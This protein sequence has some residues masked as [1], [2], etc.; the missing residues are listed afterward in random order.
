LKFN[1]VKPE[2]IPADAVPAPPGPPAPPTPQPKMDWRSLDSDLNAA[3]SIDIFNSL[4]FDSADDDVDPEVE[5]EPNDPRTLPSGVIAGVGFS[6]RG[7][8]GDQ[9]HG[10]DRGDRSQRGAGDLVA[11][12]AGLHVQL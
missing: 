2:F 5:D 4:V 7:Q 1:S 3:K 12:G 9:H 10:G 11:I 6:Y 8:R